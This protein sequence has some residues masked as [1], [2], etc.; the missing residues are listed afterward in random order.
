ML[1]RRAVDLAFAAA[2]PAV[3][4]AELGEW[5][6]RASAGVTRRGNS[7]LALGAAPALDE[8]ADWYR[9][10]DLAPRVQVVPSSPLGLA[11]SLVRE[12]WA[13][14]DGACLI[15]AAPC[16]MSL[17]DESELAV[18]AGGEPTE[19]WVD[20][21]WTVSPRGGE[22]ERRVAET[23]LARIPMPRR[24]GLAR[25]ADGSAVAC[26]LGVL[27]GG[28]LVIESS[29]TLPEA[30]RRGACRALTTDLLTWGVA[31]GATRAVLSVERTN[32][33]GLGV[34]Q[35]LGFTDLG[36]IDY[37]TLT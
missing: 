13:V 32:V 17:R 15:L 16:G 37:L 1:D 12:G 23:I 29:A 36:R 19:E 27:V 8:I 10:R 7:A 24:F 35:R 4:T 34:W 33:H 31:R 9:A 2:W 6:L 5:T 28:L 21:W 20:I 3:E 26:M 25:N 14:A 22:S 30:R 11:A 18:S